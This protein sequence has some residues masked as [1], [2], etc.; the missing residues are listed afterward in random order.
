LKEQIKMK[1]LGI[2]ENLK[3]VSVPPK[4]GYAFNY[5]V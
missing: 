5:F 2:I 3:D 1:V 4:N